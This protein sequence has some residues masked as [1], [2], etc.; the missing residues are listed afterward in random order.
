MYTLVIGKKLMDKFQNGLYG[1]QITH[2][3]SIIVLKLEQ[4]N[5]MYVDES[6]Y[7]TET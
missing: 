6:T 7:C 2:I 4:Q 1:R 3:N 5:I